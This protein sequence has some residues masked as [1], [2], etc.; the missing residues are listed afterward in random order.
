MKLLLLVV[1]ITVTLMFLLSIEDPN[2]SYEED[3][4]R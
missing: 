3:D 2:K 1:T 4:W